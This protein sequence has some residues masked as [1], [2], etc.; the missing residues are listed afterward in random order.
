[1]YTG[2]SSQNK[3]VTY[4][5]E[6]QPNKKDHSVSFKRSN[7]RRLPPAEMSEKRQK[8]LCF[9]CD[10]KFVPGHKYNAA[11]QLYLLEVCDEEEQEEQHDSDAQEVLEV[12]SE[13]EANCEISIHDLNRIPRFHTLRVVGYSE[14]AP[15]IFS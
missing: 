7:T 12:E 5:K 4:R 13:G 9:F 11:K 14:K 6:Y 3:V 8:V 2:G 1:M 10:D 15:L